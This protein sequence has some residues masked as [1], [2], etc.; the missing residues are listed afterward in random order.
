MLSAARSC[1]LAHVR[2]CHALPADGRSRHRA[3][4]ALP[5][6]SALLAG[7]LPRDARPGGTEG[8][9]LR[10]EASRALLARGCTAACGKTAMGPRWAQF[11]GAL[12]VL[13]FSPRCAETGDVR[14]GGSRW[15]LAPLW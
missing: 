11:C 3:F 2:I 15:L 9:L 14:S 8:L 13:L 10:L 12:G 6:R 7:L 1:T 4:A 5:Q